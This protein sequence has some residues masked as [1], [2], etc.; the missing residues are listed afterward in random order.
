MTK[1][2]APL[3]ADAI[4][5]IVNFKPMGLSAFERLNAPFSWYF[6]PQFIGGENIPTDRGVLFVC[7]HSV[8]G[9]ADIAAILGA[10]K[11]TGI[12]VRGLADRIHFKNPPLG[13][14]LKRAGAVVGDPQICAALMEDGQNVL[15][16][17]GGGRE[18]MKKRREVYELVWK[19]RLGFVRLAL[20]HGYDI[21]P[22]GIVGGDEIYEFLADSDDY[23]NNSLGKAFDKWGVF[24]KFLRGKDE[25]PP[26]TRGIGLSLLPKPHRLY[27]S[28]GKPINLAKHASGDDAKGQLLNARDVVAK[29]VQALIEQGFEA[30]KS[31]PKPTPFLRRLLQG[32]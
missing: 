29:A 21:V 22:V 8:W 18:V 9:L 2:T 26:L 23:L 31:D 30:R 16:F 17:P 3:S 24:D 10:Y 1:Q 19:E 11:I 28:Y 13:K 15:V 14:F 32:L 4:A 27:V 20:K 7:N 5:E 25:L 12:P 6:D